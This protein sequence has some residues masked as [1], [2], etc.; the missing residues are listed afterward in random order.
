MVATKRWL[1]DQGLNLHFLDNAVRSRT[2][3]PL[4]AGV[5]TL[6]EKSVSWQGVVASLQRM[7]EKPIHVGGLTALD[8]AGLTHFLSTSAEVR[9]QLYS[10]PPL[11]RLDQPNCSRCHLRASWHPQAMARVSHDK[12]KVSS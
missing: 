7:S 4:A 2:L 9:I 12:P 11:T 5:Y 3:I 8:L 10:E 6:Y 1:L